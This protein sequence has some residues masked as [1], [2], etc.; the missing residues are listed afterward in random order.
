MAAFWGGK[1][2][3]LLHEVA[4]SKKVMPPKRQRR[5]SI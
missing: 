2:E 5:K 1:L 4:L 3:R